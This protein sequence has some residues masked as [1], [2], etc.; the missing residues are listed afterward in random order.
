[1][2]RTAF[3][4][5]LAALLMP[6]CSPQTQ[7]VD[8]KKGG[9]AATA[10]GPDDFA[11]SVSLLGEK[12]GV[13]APGKEIRISF[14]TTRDAYVVVY[15]IDANGYVQL[16]YPE[17][18]KAVLSKGR[19][20][21]FLPAPGGDEHWVTEGTTGVEYIHALAVTD[22]D[23]INENELFFLSSGDRLSDEK[24][25]RLDMDPFLGF[26]MVDGELVRGAESDPPV[27]DYT[28]FYVNTHVEYPRYLCAKCHSP[29]KISDPYA[30][31]CPEIVI[32]KIAYEEDPH[33]PYPPLFDIQHV[34]EKSAEETY[35]S[36]S[37]ADKWLD[38]SAESDTEA[39]K[40]NDTHLYLAFGGLYPSYQPYGPY[41]GPFFL[42]FDPFYWDV[43]GGFAWGWDWWDSY[44]WPSWG[45]WYP[46]SRYWG[47][48]YRYPWWG[49]GG[50][51]W[52]AGGWGGRHFGYRPIYGS[53]TVTKKRINY[54]RTNTE[55][56][57]T[58]SLAGSRLVQSQGRDVAAR[59]DRSSLGRGVA[60]RTVGRV[61]AS[62]GNRSVV[63]NRE[64][65]RRIIYGGDTRRRSVDRTGSGAAN[66]RARSRS[67]RTIE[68]GPTRGTTGR[69]GRTV[70][71]TRGDS[72]RDQGGDRGREVIKRSEP[73]R[74]SSGSEGRGTSA[75][76]SGSS[77]GQRSGSSDR[78]GSSAGKRRTSMSASTGGAASYQR[79]WGAAASRS[80]GSWSSGAGRS[81]SRSSGFSR[82]SS[83]G[84]TR[85]R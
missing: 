55:L 81:A 28:Y 74:R 47:Y 51:G 25:L 30:M 65:D 77:P 12:G 32:E 62:A 79:T 61:A 59:L 45:W 50:D 42:G 22:L 63:R 9:Y 27:T 18:G 58:G 23:R 49:C 3:L 70:P 13:Y 57:R 80:H 1:M 85:S 84:R 33:Y 44:W 16:L 15:D 56:R 73:E 76:P 53:R 68:R 38:E 64:L 17:D 8:L 60:S 24:R 36:D 19:T 10:P 2:K 20:T 43:W 46:P 31:Q 48:C 35:T 7:A 29:E 83:G 54:E 41:T 75:R 6:L 66:V 40:A 11:V 78:S 4:F 82:G 72:G 67:S 52:Y 39:T 26:N 69:D 71:S 14:Q 5:L 34:G 21:H 37:Y